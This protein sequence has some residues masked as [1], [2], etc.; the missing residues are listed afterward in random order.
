[1]GFKIIQT[2]ECYIDEKLKPILDKVMKKKEY[3]EMS[4]L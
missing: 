2:I 4:F 1:M 3:Y